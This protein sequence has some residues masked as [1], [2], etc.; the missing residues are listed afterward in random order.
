MRWRRRQRRAQRRSQTTRSRRQRRRTRRR[1]RRSELRERRAT[2]GSLGCLPGRRG[3]AELRMDAAGA[4]RQCNAR[5]DATLTMEDSRR[6]T[7]T[8]WTLMALTGAA[9]AMAIFL[10]V[11]VSGGRTWWDCSAGEGLLLSGG[12]AGT[13]GTHV[14]YRRGIG[15][16]G[17]AEE[18]PCGYPQSAIVAP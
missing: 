6:T 4:Q 15:R 3:Q 9:L 2:R 17:I 5:G 1:Q 14:G 8:S 11:W 7:R 13:N 16:R 12:T 10:T 18:P